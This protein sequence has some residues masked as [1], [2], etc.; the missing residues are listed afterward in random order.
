MD[1]GKNCVM[2]PHTF[3]LLTARC[4][5]QTKLITILVVYLSKS[6]KESIMYKI[7]NIKSLRVTPAAF[8]SYRK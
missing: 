2:C 8:C 5:R 1:I 7:K 4:G 3:W 6:I